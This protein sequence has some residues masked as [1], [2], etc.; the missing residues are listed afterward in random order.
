MRDRPL[1]DAVSD[2][3]IWRTA[4]RVLLDQGVDALRYATRRRD[5]MQKAGDFFHQ[6]VW[7][8][9]IRVLTSLDRRQD[10]KSI[11][12]SVAATGGPVPQPATGSS[13][14]EA[15]APL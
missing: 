6:T 4:H 14:D 9:I 1:G 3:E 13:N 15:T 7:S 10:Q 11:G 5:E 8:R 12:S 2:S